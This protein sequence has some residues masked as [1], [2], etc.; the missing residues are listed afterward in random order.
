MECIL[1]Y[2][3][4]DRPDPIIE[5]LLTILSHKLAKIIVAALSAITAIYHNYGCKTVEPKPT[6]KILA[7]VFGHADKN[8]RAEA[9]NLTVELYRWLKDAMKPLFWNDLKPVQQADLEKLF[10][11]VKNEP[12]PKQERLLR[13]QQAAEETADAADDVPDEEEAE[14]ALEPDFE[15]VNVLPKVP[16]DLQERLASSKWKDRKEALDDLHKAINYPRIEEGSFDDILRSL[17]KCMKDANIGVVTVAASCVEILAKGLQR[18]FVRYR[19]IVLSPMMERLKEKKQSV[20]DAIGLALDAVFGA[21]SLGEC[22]EDIMEFI[23]HKNPQVKLESTRFLIR[24]LRNTKEVPQPPA[25]KSIADAATKLLTDSQEVQRAAGAEALGTL[26]KIIGDKAMGPHLNDLD[27]IRKGKIKEFYETAEVKAKNKPKA[28][29]PPKA[30]VAQKRMGMVGKKPAPGTR[31]PARPSSP[32]L[33]E[34]PPTPAPVARQPP[35][36]VSKIGGPKSGGLRPPAGMQKR[37]IQPP[38]GLSSPMRRVA[39]PTDES[40]PPPPP[41]LGLG[42]NRGLAARPLGKPAPP[43]EPSAPVVTASGLS[44][45]GSAERAELEELRAETERLRRETEHQRADKARLASQLAELTNQNAQLIE[46]HTRDV[47]S[48]KAKETQLIRARSDAEALE[49]AMQTQ[50]REIDRLKRELGR[51]VRASSPP[52]LDLLAGD[53]VFSPAAVEAAGTNYARRSSRSFGASPPA[54]KGQGAGAEGKENFAPSEHILSLCVESVLTRE[55]GNVAGLGLG[56][57]TGYGAGSPR[58]S[59]MMQP[60]QD[61]APTGGYAGGGAGAAGGPESWKRAAEVTQNLKARIEMMK[62]CLLASGVAKTL[63]VTGEAGAHE[64][65]MIPV[66]LAS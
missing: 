61:A 2:V 30:A 10:E 51:Q 43:P 16:K 49:Q 14:F 36:S 44:G 63:T 6:V 65:E 5:E 45:L 59:R 13:S 18:S 64:A 40:P 42:A 20:T 50:Q 35:K 11:A 66:M 55:T 12:P 39:S 21:T 23:K 27:D 41:K 37:G 34:D 26:W 56:M 32:P 4:L 46:D 7:K 31:K 28:A 3:E 8:V 48:V 54:A 22:L 19:G 62:V 33:M 1:L 15:P 53:G 24:C 38:S 25:V 17:A 57:G 58:S 52:P 47:L 60:I 29:P 9:T